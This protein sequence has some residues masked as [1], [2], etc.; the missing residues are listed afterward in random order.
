MS[1]KTQSQDTADKYKWK[2]VLFVHLAPNEEMSPAPQEHP[3]ER[4]GAFVDTY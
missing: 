1:E 3:T 2:D 4:E